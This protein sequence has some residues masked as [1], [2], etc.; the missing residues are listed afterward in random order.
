MGG[1]PPSG[2]REGFAGRRRKACWGNF[3]EGEKGRR[4]GRV[5]LKKYSLRL[6]LYDAPGTSLRNLS[7]PEILV[8]GL[9]L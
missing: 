5:D 1:K 4:G 9:I 6:S 8:A 3:R 7:S 2:A